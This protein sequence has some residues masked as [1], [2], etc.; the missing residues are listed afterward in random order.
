[1]EQCSYC[2]FVLEALGSNCPN[3]GVAVPGRPP[4]QVTV[5]ESAQPRQATHY[6]RRRGWLKPLLAL[7]LVAG[8]LTLPQAQPFL[9]ELDDLWGELN[10]AYYEVPEA[11]T[12]TV[13]RNFT[14]FLTSDPSADYRL[15][16]SEPGHRPSGPQG[17]GNS[18]QEIHALNA[19]PAWDDTHAGK[20]LWE[21]HIS[22]GERVEI[23]VSYSVTVSTIQSNLKA[24]ETGTVNDYPSEYDSYLQD[25]WKVEPS[26]TQVQELALQFSNGTDGNV[27]RILRNIFDYVMGNFTYVLGTTPKSC[28]QT[29]A[30]GY[31]DCDDLGLL[32][33]SIARAA[34]IPAWM[35]LGMIP[36]SSDGLQDWG[37][38]AWV[39]ALVPL[40]GGNYTV[41]T[42]DLANGYFL[43]MPPYRLSEYVDNG[44]PDD[45]KAFYFLFSSQGSGRASFTQD[46]SVASYSEQGQ[47]RIEA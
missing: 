44:D 14:I 29:L 6:R 36:R 34:G 16:L 31:G 3:C 46:I 43:W 32:Y 23:S 27:L 17:A 30:Y 5:T 7:L 13:M 47:L 2:G 35:E 38:H 9:R 20:M 40:T 12:M 45:L 28:E 33:V 41:V 42:V 15:A 25:E 10:T 22:D 8:L 26:N 18:W 21:G 39:N 1:M 19:T 11:V 4:A 24:E 37:G